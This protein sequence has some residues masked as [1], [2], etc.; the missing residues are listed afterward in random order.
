MIIGEQ[1]V[2]NVS[3]LT[4]DLGEISFENDNIMGVKIPLI[5][6]N[7]IKTD[8]ITSYGFIDTCARLDD[9][10]KKFS[11]IL[12]TKNNLSYFSLKHSMNY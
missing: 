2:E 11:N 9:A 12:S 10:Q 7:E 6:A 8:I 4:E 5:N 1:K 3:L